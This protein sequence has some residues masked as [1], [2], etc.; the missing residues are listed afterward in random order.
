MPKRPQ[1]GPLENDPH[2]RVPHQES[3]GEKHPGFDEILKMVGQLEGRNSYGAL[4]TISGF[5]QQV[6]ELI[7]KRHFD[8]E[9]LIDVFNGIIGY[10][11]SK[12]DVPA[13]DSW[14]EEDFKEL[15]R[16][17]IKIGEE[18]HKARE[19]RLGLEIPVYSFDGRSELQQGR[20]AM[21]KLNDFG[22]NIK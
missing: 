16:A 18:I 9:Q 5:E 21:E 3:Q 6:H 10:Q 4:D 17:L 1:V 2:E 8:V 22:K 7:E 20:D 19:K 14:K 13:R 12:I 15:D 11:F